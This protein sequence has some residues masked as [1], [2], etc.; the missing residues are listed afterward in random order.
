[1]NKLSKINEV[2]TSN[3]VDIDISYLF[4]ELETFDELNEKVIEYI[5]SR[6]IIYYSKAM[7]YL[8]E[9]DASLSESLEIAHEYGYTTENLNSELL[10]TLLYQHNLSTEWYEISEQIETILND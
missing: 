4:D 7:T 8:S 10:A 6:E 9:N 5:N 1:M 2:I 3:Y